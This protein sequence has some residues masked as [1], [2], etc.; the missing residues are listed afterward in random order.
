[1]TLKRQTPRQRG[2]EM[3]RGEKDSLKS[4]RQINESQRCGER[5]VDEREKQGKEGRKGRRRVNAAC[6]L[7]RP[8]FNQR[9]LCSSNNLRKLAR[10]DTHRV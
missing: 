6:F 7:T 3:E 10:L 1:M 2:E 5:T 4:F 8:T 9:C